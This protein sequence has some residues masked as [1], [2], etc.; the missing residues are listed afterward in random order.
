MPTPRVL[1]LHGWQGSGPEHWQSRLAGRLRDRGVGVRY[2]E[3]PDP[4][5][6]KLEPW[7]DAVASEL[8]ALTS[9]P[10]DETVVLC[11][12]LGA[13]LWLHHAARTPATPVDRV[14]LV[15]PP[16]PALA[17]PELAEFLPAPLDRASLDA[18]AGSTRIV[19][20]ADDPY[21]P[22]GAAFSYGLPLGLPLDEI[23]PGGHLNSDAGYGP[24]PAVEAWALDGAA[25]P[26]SS[27]RPR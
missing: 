1:I 20:A 4:D 19:C 5:N 24:W 26:L 6:P 3:L 8:D 17:V 21:C 25:T 16:S 11:H 15:S 7:L 18:A 12:S 9:L 2:P 14:L 13:A 27:N 23:T 10:G 22:E